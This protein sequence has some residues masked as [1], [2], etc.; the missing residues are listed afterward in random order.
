MTPREK[1][2]LLNQVYMHLEQHPEIM[3]AFAH[4]SFIEGGPFRD[5]DIAI[6]LNPKFLSD[7]SFRYEMQIESRIK[8]ELKI[9]FK[10]DV[11]ILNRAP[12]SF[13][14]HALRGRLLL[15]REPDARIAFTTQ[16]AGRYLDIEPILKHH[17]REA[18]AGESGS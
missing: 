12:L 13:R 18:F 15:D 14:Y 8:K 9:P 17:T 10:V 7:I 6:F 16:T 4:G 11:R 5:L 2:N 3:F 1:E